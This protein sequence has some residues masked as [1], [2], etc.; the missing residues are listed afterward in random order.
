MNIQQLETLVKNFAP[1]A[2]LTEGK[3]FPEVSVTPDDLKILARGL[4]DDDTA[5]LDFLVCLTGVDYGEDLGVVYH[6]RSTRHQH[7]VVLK[8][9]T[10]DRQHPELDTV[11]DIWKAAEYHENEVFDLLGIRFK[12]HP[13]LRRLFLDEDT[14]YPLRK[15][16]VDEVNIVTK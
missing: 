10:S 12:G 3:Q 16:F 13:G 8:T 7:T 2:E 6:L 14:G 1:G 11:S 15:D 9:R 4:R 5:N